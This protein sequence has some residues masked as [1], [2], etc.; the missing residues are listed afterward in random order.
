M[1]TNFGNSVRQSQK[2]SSV[3]SRNVRIV[4]I[5]VDFLASNELVASLKSELA[6]EKALG[7]QSRALQKQLKDRDSEV[8]RLESQADDLTDHLSSAQSEVKSLQTKLA[9]ARNTAANI[10]NAAAKIPGSA[11]KKNPVNRINSAASAEAAQAAQ[12]AQLK[13]DLY[14]DLTGLIVRDVK[15][16]ES[17]SLY[18]CI[19]TGINGSLWPSVH[20]CHPMFVC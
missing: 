14:S 10:E 4:D 9:A 6:A 7:Q 17:D 8:A 3:I 2:V 16:R 20:A 19:Q 18:D 13:E 5:F 1:W 11:L 12:I 15:K